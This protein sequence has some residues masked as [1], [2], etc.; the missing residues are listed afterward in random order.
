M[1]D[2]FLITGS[3]KL[4]CRRNFKLVGRAEKFEELCTI[5]TRMESN[6]VI[7]SGPS[8]VG[9]TTLA[10]ALQ[11]RKA[12]PD[13]PFD[14]VNKR[15]FW[16][17][18]DGLFGLGDNDAIVSQ[19]KAIFA[20]LNRTPDSV[21]IVEDT[22]DL[23]GALHNSGLMHIVNAL[24]AMVK[25]KKTQVFLEVREADLT[26]VLKC[27]SDFRDH[28]TLM[29]LTEPVGAELEEIALHGARDLE[30][31]YEVRID[32]A[33]VRA[34]IDMSSK[35]RSL[36]TGLTAAQ[37]A[38]TRTL[39]D[40]GMARYLLR[41]H[42][43]PPLLAELE[44]ELARLTTSA[45][46]SGNEE[47]A[48]TVRAAIVRHKAEF[49]DYQAKIKRY[50]G[51]QR[52][53]EKS[54]AQMEA[55]LRGLE[56]EEKTRHLDDPA[57]KA[58]AG[59]A[60]F[61]LI[62]RASG[63]A[64]PEILKLRGDIARTQAAVDENRVKYKA[65]TKEINDRLLFTAG[66]VIDEFSLISGIDASKLKQNDAVKL[67][68]LHGALKRR[69]FGQD[70]V[71]E[72]VDRA[73]KV[74]RRGRRTDR[75][76]PFLF[77]GA[78]GVG[79]TEVSKGLAEALFD[80]DKALNRYDMG[81]FMEKNDVTK[82]IGAPPGYDGFAAGGEMTN[83]VRANPYQVMLWDEIEK[84]HPDIFNICL[85]ILDDGRCRDNLG[86]KVEFG[87]VA[88]PMTTNIGADHALRV[89]TGPGDLSEDE[90]YELTIRDLKKAFRTEFLNRFEGRENIILF[91]KLNM[92]TIE[93]IVFREISRINAF[94]AQQS[95][96]V[97]FPE[98]QLREFCDKTYSPEIGARGLPGRIKRI[99]AMIV[100]KTMADAAISGTLDIGFDATSRNFTSNWI[101]HDRKAA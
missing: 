76:L 60:D 38:R 77:C 29:D 64:T 16:L 62:A 39:L 78:S 91:R 81:E 44:A 24:T 51:A 96:D 13:A 2:N 40:R 41:A 101:P 28:F 68:N 22:L 98:A 99:E 100:E 82:L 66:M 50:Y 80:T 32:P 56:D 34:A 9:I 61:N 48:A 65:V 74:W 54:I 12:D 93:K 3:E 6:S 67:L 79:K 30:E 84:A 42:S 90:A 69:V 72:H 46:C 21:L 43:T 97:R 73:V 55:Q 1:A 23:I 63:Y 59:D 35:Y 49:A 20:T 75:P 36:D 71:L 58:S 52:E 95:I 37:P 47:K 7:V 4:A 85:N 17:D 45:P 18:T 14:I 53:G 86:R 88:M 26:Q 8:G 15:L 25:A 57:G 87:D 33:A 11:A 19:F 31:S 83:S 92:D 94:Y 70:A 89:G 27:H 5:L 10:L